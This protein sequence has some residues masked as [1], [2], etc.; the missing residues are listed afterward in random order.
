ME[1]LLV[2]ILSNVTETVT[3]L[4][5]VPSALLRSE[6]GAGLSLLSQVKGMGALEPDLRESGNGG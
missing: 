6:D 5:I 3:F 1:Y 2:H 4:E